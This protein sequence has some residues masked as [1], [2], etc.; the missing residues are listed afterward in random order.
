M[1]FYFNFP[2]SNQRA[3]LQFIQDQGPTAGAGVSVSPPETTQAL[4]VRGSVKGCDR[5]LPSYTV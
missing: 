1:V 3:Q 5:T 2:L 4:A